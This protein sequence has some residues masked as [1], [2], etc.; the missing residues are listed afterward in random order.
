LIE[1]AEPATV[2]RAV[3]SVT[4]TRLASVHSFI[5]HLVALPK[6]LLEAP[7]CLQNVLTAAKG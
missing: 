4:L 6:S 3:P 5:H 2:I 7:D 1:T